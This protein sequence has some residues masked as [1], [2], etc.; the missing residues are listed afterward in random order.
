MNFRNTLVTFAA[1]LLT[2]AVT[3][4]GGREGSATLTERVDARLG[5]VGDELIELRRDL[6]RHPELSGEEERTAGV[7]AERLR[8]LGLEV[9]T[10]V[11]GHGV[12]ALLRGGKPGPVVA[13]RADMDA[14]RSDEP[15]PVPFKSVNEGV[16]H[17]C[18]HDI[19][20][21][22]G[23]AVAEGLAAVRED[24]PGTVKLL[25]QPA[26]EQARGAKA[27]IADGAMEDPAPEVIFAVH[28]APLEV[29]QIGTK[30]GV[31][32][33]GSDLVTVKL[34]GE[35]DLKKAADAV[36]EIIAGASTLPRDQAMVPQTEDFWLGRVFRSEP[37][38]ENGG[39]TVTGIATTTS[40]VLREKAKEELRAKLDALAA[41]G[42]TVELDYEARVIAGAFNDPELEKS[43]H[44]TIR[45]VVGE[46]A[47]VPL[48][49]VIPMFSEDFGSFQ[50]EAKG[51]M[52][53]LGVS[54]TE[55]GIVG[56]PHSPGY[57]ADED[58][59]SVGARTMAAVILDYLES[60]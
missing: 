32:L 44:E 23:V 48:T 6:H 60:N 30:A 10:G 16:R 47:L 17:I 34:T 25:F 58:S 57:V 45:G 46:D 2:L 59:I 41:E 49:T 43:T 13:Y 35:G 53:F 3:P 22:I 42:V 31:L 56:M 9:E 20:T 4:A 29:G 28:T 40:D 27:M 11:G 37:D 5:A 50:D 55:K 21:A 7:V 24:L 51:V 39:W 15:D 12:V 36:A 1:L 14:V 33:A 38:G 8:R 18:G 19:H 52:Y 26:E 54:N